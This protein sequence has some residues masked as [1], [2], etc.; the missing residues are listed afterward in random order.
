[1]RTE[2]RGPGRDVGLHAWIGAGSGVSG[3][4]SRLGVGRGERRGSGVGW[5]A[6]GPA[7]GVRGFDE[8][9]RQRCMGLT[10]FL[11][12]FRMGI[13]PARGSAKLFV[14]RPA[15]GVRKGLERVRET[16]QS[17]L[18]DT[19]RDTDV[20]RQLRGNVNFTRIGAD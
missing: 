9:A 16:L 3:G 19:E 6:E 17:T 14:G 13:V 11:H 8:S 1:M 18:R 2:A 4:V 15:I 12:P 20:P 5:L 7:E 10:T